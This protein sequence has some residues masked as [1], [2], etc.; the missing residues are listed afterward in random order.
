MIGLS[1]SGISVYVKVNTRRQPLVLHLRYFDLAD[2]LE[3]IPGT[4]F[5][6]P[7]RPYVDSNMRS[8]SLRVR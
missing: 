1:R 2:R 4:E 3:K 5:D 7:L 6:R 8:L